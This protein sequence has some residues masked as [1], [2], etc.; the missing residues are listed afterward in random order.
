MWV[1]LVPTSG[2]LRAASSG[3]KRVLKTLEAGYSPDD[4]ALS[5][6]CQARA[7]ISYITSLLFSPFLLH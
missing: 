7:N 5:L 4:R 3:K 2:A 6:A 1:S